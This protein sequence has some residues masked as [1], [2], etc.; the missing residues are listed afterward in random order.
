MTLFQGL[1][2]VAV[3]AVIVTVIGYSKGRD[4][5][6]RDG[7]AKPRNWCVVY[8]FISDEGKFCR[9]LTDTGE[10]FIISKASLKRYLNKEELVSCPHHLKICFSQYLNQPHQIISVEEI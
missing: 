2:V 4:D 6:E 1:L 10:E 3:V 8:N 7:Q 5:G 9:F